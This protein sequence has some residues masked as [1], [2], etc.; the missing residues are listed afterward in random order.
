MDSAA[1]HFG[2]FAGR[3]PVESAWRTVTS[4]FIHGS[5]FHLA[6][7]MY[8]LRVFGDNVEDLLG[9]WRFVILLATATAFGTLAF[10]CL[11]PHQTLPLIGASG[12]I[13]G[14]IVYYLIQFPRRRSLFTIYWRLVAVPGYLFAGLYFARDVALV[15]LGITSNV[16]GAS[17][18][19]VGG[20]IA[21]GLL[22]LAWRGR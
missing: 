12:G 11:H 18:A 8:F 1:A 20:A 17:A 19:H 7:N 22:A 4:F 5:L 9:R 2:F 3:G 16:A 21:G 14:V 10:A 15:A 6:A 13:S